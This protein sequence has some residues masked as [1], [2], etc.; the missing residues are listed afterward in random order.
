MKRAEK[1]TLAEIMEATGWQKHTV[2]A[3]GEK[4]GASFLRVADDPLEA[5]CKH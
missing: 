2:T 3:S 5:R 4:S 1:A